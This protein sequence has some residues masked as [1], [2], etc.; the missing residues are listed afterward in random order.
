M[1]L[2]SEILNEIFNVFFA[3]HYVC[4]INSISVRDSYVKD[5]LK[6]MIVQ[7]DLAILVTWYPS[8]P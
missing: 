7:L 8:S 3:H 4:I 1:I 6:L 2:P 5:H